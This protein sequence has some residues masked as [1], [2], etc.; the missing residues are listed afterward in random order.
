[1][2]QHFGGK[3]WSVPLDRTGIMGILNC[4]PDSFSDGGKYLDPPQAIRH[5]KAL[6]AAGA[7]IVDIG[8][9][10]TRP[11]YR[12][13]SP[14]EEWERIAPVILGLRQALPALI[15]SVD[16]FYPAVAKKALLAGV[17]ILNDVTGFSA[18]MMSVASDSDCGCIL[19]HPRRITQ[20][21]I[22]TEVRDFFRTK[23][24]QAESFG[25][26]KSRL[27]MDPGI[28]FG[29][30][31][32]DNLRLIANVQRTKLPDIAY[33]MALSKKRVIGIPCNRPPFDQ[34][35]SGTLAANTVAILGG[36]NL[37]RV[38][39]VREARQAALVTDALLAASCDPSCGL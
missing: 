25:I 39:D 30:R 19:M 18:E 28:G 5:G 23:Q 33:L 6:A 14:Q 12:P 11:G 29:K 35:L 20:G 37:L 22:L 8:G 36:A 13:I 26:R 7:D 32:P 21:D 27:C 3:T 1:M 34:R 4:T 15:L 2:P 10:S 9:Q 16:S 17:Q 24:A 38:H 31:H